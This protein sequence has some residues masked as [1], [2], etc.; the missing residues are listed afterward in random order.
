MINQKPQK[1]I[2]SITYAQWPWRNVLRLHQEDIVV[3]DVMR[4]DGVTLRQLR[5]HR[6]D[7]YDVD[8]IAKWMTDLG[9]AP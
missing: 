7:P 2:P 5:R 9:D 6:C 4:G 3:R 1:E 8:E